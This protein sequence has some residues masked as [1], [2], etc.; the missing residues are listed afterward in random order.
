MQS[1]SNMIRHMYRYPTSLLAFILRTLVL[2][3]K[4][5]TSFCIESDQVMR[6][7]KTTQLYSSTLKSNA[8][9]TKVHQKT[10]QTLMSSSFIQKVIFENFFF[11]KNNTPY[12]FKPCF[13]F[14]HCRFL[15]MA[16][17]NRDSVFH[18]FPSNSEIHGTIEFKKKFIRVL[19]FW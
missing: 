5:F 18:C 16:K 11:C 13:M 14:L 1:E 17:N 7:P 8:L 2:Y 19:K 3:F 6:R 15:W 9:K 12:L 10:Q 4:L